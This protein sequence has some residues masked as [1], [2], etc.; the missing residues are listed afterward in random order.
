MLDVLQREGYIRGCSEE[1][2][3]PAKGVRIELKY[4]EG[5]P[6][7]VKA[8]PPRTL[9]VRVAVFVAVVILENAHE[10][11]CCLSQPPA[12]ARGPHHG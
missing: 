6:A 1:D 10:I 8:V 5:Q 12:A 11:V 7:I 3:G 4:V 9:C 2:L